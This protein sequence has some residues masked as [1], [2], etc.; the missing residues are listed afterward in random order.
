[1]ATFSDRFKALRISRNL[2][3]EELGKELGISKG[4]VN[5]YEHSARQPKFEMLETIADFFNVDMDYLLGKSDIPN[6]TLVS[7][8]G[9][10]PF[11]YDNIL[12]ITTQRLPLLGE[13]A[14]GE[15]IFADEDKETYIEVGTD[16]KAD[17]CLKCKGDSMIGARIL[18]GD[19]VFIK[20]QSTVENGEIAAVIIENEATLKRVYYYNEKNLLILKPENATYEDIIFNGTELDQIKI[21]G[22]AVAFQSVIK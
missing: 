20:Q 4:A 21:L 14:C 11:Q 17:F 1:M 18:D 6:R 13:I 15:P 2:S 3:Q 10:N 7:G 5:N 22:K 12:P 16:I 9:M 8:C 19:I